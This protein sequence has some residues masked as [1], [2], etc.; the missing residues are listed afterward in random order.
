MKKLIFSLYRGIFARKMFYGF[1]KMLIRLAYRGM[2][3]LNYESDKASGEDYL[4][5]QILPKII[6]SKSII[7]D[8]GANVG[9]FSRTLTVKFP[10]AQIYSFEPHPQNFQKLLALKDKVNCVEMALG[11]KTETAEIFD[12]SS[13]KA[14][15]HA[16]LIKEV[17]TDIHHSDV[18]R[19]EIKVESLDNFLENNQIA[20]IDFLKIDTEGFEIDV[21][22]GAEKSLAA[23]KVK[24]ILFEFNSMNTLRKVF[25]REFEA[26]LG[27]YRLYRLLPKGILPLENEE[28]IFKEIFAFQNI[29][30]VS[31]KIDLKI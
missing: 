4:I 1:N 16:S 6:K 17:I 10:D 29:L 3:I 24:V 27:E 8:V 9:N 23:G 13:G 19:I 25:F 2:G 12:Y 26:I 20:E 18:H 30:A 11:S 22:Q 21:L 15:E 7:F 5:K 14:S 28:I 31:R